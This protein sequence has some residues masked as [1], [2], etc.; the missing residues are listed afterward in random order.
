[1]F[2]ILGKEFDYEIFDADKADVYENALSR[3][4]STMEAMGKA[5]QSLS[6]AQVIRKQCEAVAECFDTV[7][8]DGSAVKIFDGEV[9]LKLA[10]I[11]FKEMVIGINNKKSEIENLAKETVTEFSATGLSAEQRN[12]HHN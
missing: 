5:S 10:M 11:A 3:V 4:T 1:M 2:T 8:G 12:E 7:F 6:Y 9:N